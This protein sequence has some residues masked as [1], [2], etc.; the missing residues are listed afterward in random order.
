LMCILVF[1][2]PAFGYA[3]PVPVNIFSLQHPKKD[4]IW[5]SLAGVGANL[6]ICSACFVVLLVIRFSSLNIGYFFPVV[7]ILV[8]GVFINLVLFFFN[9]IPVPPLDG[10]KVLIG[11]LPDRFAMKVV[12]LEPFGFILLVIL[13]VTNVLNY[14]FYPVLG[15]FDILM[16]IAGLSGI[17]GSV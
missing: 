14:F 9:L 15:F 2:M 4:M 3:K 1:K 11:V 6:V 17:S 5:V 8:Y 13:M 7:K 12:R 10:S 16:S